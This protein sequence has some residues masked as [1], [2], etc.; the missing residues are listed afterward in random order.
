MLYLLAALAS[1][2]QLTTQKKTA[3][4]LNLNGTVITQRNAILRALCTVGPLDVYPLCLL[5]QSS[6]AGLVEEMAVV[7]SNVHSWMSI[8]ST[9]GKGK[10][11][12]LDA[13]FLNSLNDHLNNFAFLAG[14]PQP[15][16]ADWTV[17]FSMNNA[18]S[19]SE[20]NDI[21]QS[22]GRAVQRW[23]DATQCSV[24][25]AA[26]GVSNQFN[27]TLLPPLVEFQM[28]NMLPVFHYP[29]LAIS[30]AGGGSDSA[31]ANEGSKDEKGK[32]KDSKTAPQQSSGGELTDE[33][34]KAA[35]DKRAKKAAEKAAKKKNKAPAAKQEGASGGEYNIS[36][37]DIR[38]GKILKAWEHPEAD[39]LYCEEI[40]VGEDKPRQIASGLRPFYKLEQ[41]QNQR[42]LVL[43]NLKARPLLGFASHGMVLCASN[44]DHTSVEFAVPPD[45]AAIGERVFFDSF[46]GGEPEAENKMNKKKILE[47]V[48]PDL[49]T[50]A[51][52][53]VVWKN[54]VSKTSAGPCR[55]IHG[56]K[57]AQVA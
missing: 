46:E 33:Q 15:S 20:L 2:K 34:K 45:G 31:T 39:K 7:M 49:K 55:A 40:D 4:E 10:K 24:H 25:D 21:L 54:K 26:E 41:M 9:I 19:A 42:V 8:A 12:A 18:V 48:A 37:F 5:G 14:T 47:K 44:A 43:C 38:V 3:I 32:K 17:Y 52:G 1:P 11:E 51:D 6:V 36:A 23:Y 16:L 22:S 35:A 29:T 57:D 28:Q 56:M 53:V 50:N 13:N 30:T 27:E